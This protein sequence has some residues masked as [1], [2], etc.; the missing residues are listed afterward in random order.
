MIKDRGVLEK[1][2]LFFINEIITSKDFDNKTLNNIKERL[3][4]R[5]ILDAT[6]LLNR[7]IPL[8]TVSI[9]VLYALTEA[10]YE[11]TRL[12]FVNPQKYFLD[13][14]IAIYKTFKKDMFEES[15]VIEFD[16][17]IQIN[18]SHWIG[19]ISIQYLVKLYNNLKIN[20]N[21]QT[22]RESGYIEKEDHLIFVPKTYPQSIR[23]IQKAI[24]DGT[25]EPDEI[26]LN[27]LKN[28]EEDFSYKNGKLTIFEGKLDIIDG[29]HRSSAIL[30]A[31]AENPELEMYFEL[32]LVNF[33]IQKAR[34]FIIQKNKQRKINEKHIQ[35]M[36]VS[37]YHNSIARALNESQKSDFKGKIVT[38]KHLVN[39]GYG[40]ITFDVIADAIDANFDIKT[41]TQSDKIQDYLIEFFNQV[42]GL[43]YNEFNT[44]TGIYTEPFSFIGY[45]AIASELYGVDG[46]KDMLKNILNQIDL[47]ENNSFY[48]EMKQ[49]QINISKANIKRISKYFKEIIEKDGGCSE[50]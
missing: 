22:Q 43:Y 25:Y 27:L 45:V 49:Y 33:D 30:K 6:R 34:D 29:W 41:R 38:T 47:T 2:L 26:T 7:N 4:K 24:L 37:S 48:Q 14:E 23:E 20:Y 3:Y 12:H 32:R 15:N 42:Y 18:Q 35:S 16:N 31:V 28:G 5:N 10:I 9:Q 19:R 8:N 11:G 40:L 1:Q 21:P 44:K 17:M 50:K 36:N 46:W 13:N 39:R